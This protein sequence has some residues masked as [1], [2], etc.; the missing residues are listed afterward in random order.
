M[1]HNHFLQQEKE[2]MGGNLDAIAYAAIDK[3]LG[4]HEAFTKV[5]F[6]PKAAIKNHII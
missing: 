6:W 1:V 5:R 2:G 4:R 3:P